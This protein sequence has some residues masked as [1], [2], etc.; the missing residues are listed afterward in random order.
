MDPDRKN[1]QIIEGWKDLL[2]KH[3][4]QEGYQPKNPQDTS[5]V[6]RCLQMEKFPPQYRPQKMTPK[7]KDEDRSAFLMDPDKLRDLKRR[8][9]IQRQ[10]SQGAV[11]PVSAQIPSSQLS[12]SQQPHSQTSQSIS[13]ASSSEQARQDLNATV[14]SLS[15]KL[16]I[17][18]PEGLRPSDILVRN[19]SQ[20]DQDNKDS[21]D[22]EDESGDVV[23]SQAPVSQQSVRLWDDFRVLVTALTLTD[24]LLAEQAEKSVADLGLDTLEDGV[25]HRLCVNEI[26]S[27]TNQEKSTDP[28]GDD[29]TDEPALGLSYQSSLRLYRILFLRKA[30]ELKSIPSRLFLDAALCASRGHGRAM[31]DGVLLPLVQDYA[32]FSKFI[33][34]LVQKA[35]KEQTAAGLTHF[36]SQILE[37]VSGTHPPTHPAHGKDETTQGALYSTPAVFASEIHL[38]TVQTLLGFASLPCPLPSRLWVRLNT[39]LELLWDQMVGLLSSV[40]KLGSTPPSTTMTLSDIKDKH[41]ADLWM[42]KLYCSPAL[43]ETLFKGGDQDREAM[44]D[45][46][47]LNNPK[48]IQLLM[49]W[50]LRQGPHCQDVG[51][52]I[53]FRE[54]CV[55]RLDPKQGKALVAKLDMIIKKKKQAA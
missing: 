23:L 25:L 21:S 40:T 39:S 9:L 26:F 53:R 8:K 50:T 16:E 1:R 29:A 19:S 24:P 14:S 54:F 11:T 27:D 2:R 13:R 4:Q 5:S 32:N 38:T 34:E 18:Q 43:W 55:T 7:E 46:L 42:L 52:L 3:D 28:T 6:H 12:S 45:E 15:S 22:G 44:K 35:L 31:V 49:A 37:P 36:L 17:L 47:R 30:T 48:L 10:N 33:S 41:Q 20:L 51:S